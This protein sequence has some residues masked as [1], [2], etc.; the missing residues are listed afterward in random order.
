ML[1]V[2]ITFHLSSVDE[3]RSCPELAEKVQL[4]KLFSFLEIKALFFLK[5]V[6]IPGTSVDPQNLKWFYSS[7]HGELWAIKIMCHIEEALN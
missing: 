1:A 5:A 6:W 4:V 3:M 2:C 7:N